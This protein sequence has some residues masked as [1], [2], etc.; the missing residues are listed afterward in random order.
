MGNKSVKCT[1]NNLNCLDKA[2]LWHGKGIWNWKQIFVMGN[3]KSYLKN[4]ETKFCEIYSNKA[5]NDHDLFR[6]P[7]FVFCLINK[8]EISG[9]WS[10]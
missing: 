6:Y 2:T 9:L 4:F 1:V 8:L 5:K 10:N 7:W 3:E